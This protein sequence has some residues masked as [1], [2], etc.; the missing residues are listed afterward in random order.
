ME[1]TGK[2]IFPAG[3]VATL[4]SGGTY[5]LE[6]SNPDGTT[7]SGNSVITITVPPPAGLAN[8]SLGIP[9][10]I[11]G[12]SFINAY[13]GCVSFRGFLRHGLCR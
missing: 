9:N 7:R 6:V 10:F 8:V 13:N 12:A 1:G 11:S 4:D 2:L 5:F 3:T